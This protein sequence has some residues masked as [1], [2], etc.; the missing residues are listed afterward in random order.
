VFIVSL[1]FFVWR[2]GVLVSAVALFVKL[3]YDLSLPGAVN[4]VT[5]GIRR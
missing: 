1:R 4:T 2:L 5:P 3:V